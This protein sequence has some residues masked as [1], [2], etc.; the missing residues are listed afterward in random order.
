M[1]MSSAVP[2]MRVPA[3]LTNDPLNK[4]LPGDF[5]FDPMGLA[6]RTLPGEL[7]TYLEEVCR[8]FGIKEGFDKM[9]WYRE[10]ELMHGR[11]AMLACFNILWR[12]TGDVFNLMPTVMVENDRA[13]WWGLLQFMSVFE[14]YRGYRLLVDVNALA[15]DLGLG[16]GPG[17]VTGEPLEG[18]VKRQLQELINGRLAMIGFLGMY[19]QHMKT[20]NWVIQESE[21][22]ELQDA[23]RAVTIPGLEEYTGP[24]VLAS[25]A[26][27]AADGVRR[28]VALAKGTTDGATGN[29][30]ATRAA[31]PL[32]VVSGV[33]DPQ[34]PLPA[35][36]EVGSLAQKLELTEAQVAKFEEDGVIIIRGAMKEWA[37]FL[38]E[39]TEYQV[40]NP[41]VWSLVGRMSG[42]YDYIQRNTWM[43]NN[44]MRDFLYYSPL[45]HILS[46]L[47]RTPEIRITTDLLMVNPNKGFGW[48]Q[49][50]QNGPISHDDC[51][52]WWVAMDP[53][54]ENGIGAPEYLRGSHRNSSVSTDAVFVNVED[55]D[56][57]KYVN[58]I[59]SFVCEPGDLIV[60]HGRSVHR[61][62]APP[63]QA[64]VDGTRRRSLGGTAAKG[65]TIYRDLGGAQAISDLAGHD[66]K[67]GELLNSPYF[68]RIYPDRPADEMALRAQGG[69]VDRSPKRIVDLA[70][71]LTSNAGKYV[72]FAKVVGKKGSES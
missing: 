35:G 28:N 7:D 14:A 38:G 6:S 55:G 60:W 48:H 21:V 13:S 72:S 69:I 18:V 45:G 65:G 67:S 5:G 11:L 39:V 2:F 31:N 42:L 34:V 68:P 25:V 1:T 19:V 26:G 51:L 53:C 59:E 41:N 9:R 50:N 47:G 71:N 3:G 46:Q 62:L 61:I 4:R 29:S 44:G 17:G 23:I 16:M 64:W 33:Q 12:E 57:P 36:V 58:D 70:V 37:K 43:T 54:G 8:N 49:D 20:G 56:L 10:A 66:Q 40:S 30:Y 27:L 22:G 15:G 63:G 32:A 24:A 52:R